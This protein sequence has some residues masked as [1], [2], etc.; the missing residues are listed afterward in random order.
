MNQQAYGHLSLYWTP[1]ISNLW[2]Y[3]TVLPGDVSVLPVDGTPSIPNPWIYRTIFRGWVRYSKRRLYIEG[4]VAKHECTD[5]YDALLPLPPCVHCWNDAPDMCEALQDGYL[6]SSLVGT[7]NHLSLCTSPDISYSAGVLSRYL[8]AHELLIG[9]LHFISYAS[10][11]VRN[12]KALSMELTRELKSMHMLCT[13]G[14]RML[15]RWLG[16]LLYCMVPMLLFSKLN[17]Y[18]LGYFDP[19]NICLDNKYK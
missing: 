11:R 9:E 17:K 7:L 16:T 2:I 10:S 1:S 8:S 4:M 6:Y 12:G 14:G 19:G 15:G 13:E 18:F 3:Q 5:E